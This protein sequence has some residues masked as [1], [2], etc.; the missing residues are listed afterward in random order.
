MDAEAVRWN[1]PVFQMKKLGWKLQI[2]R[3]KKNPDYQQKSLNFGALEE[4]LQGLTSGQSG[5]FQIA[6]EG[7]LLVFASDSGL[8][9]DL[10][11]A[12]NESFLI[13]DQKPVLES[14]LQSVLEPV[15]PEGFQIACQNPVLPSDCG[16]LVHVPS[17]S[18]GCVQN[19]FSASAQGIIGDLQDLCTVL[20]DRNCCFKRIWSVEQNICRTLRRWWFLF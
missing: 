2:Q 1:F 11:S 6:T 15:H 5:D 13:D 7:Q 17:D 19:Q 10:E 16:A 8:E 14:G 3:W 9:T 20:R 12:G 18:A 4:S